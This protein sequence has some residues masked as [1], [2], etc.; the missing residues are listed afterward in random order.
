MTLP[1]LRR[2]YQLQIGSYQK[3]KR[4]FHRGHWLSASAKASRS[5]AWKVS[6]LETRG[7]VVN[8]MGNETGF[9]NEIEAVF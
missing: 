2:R 5:S 7:F 1:S 9:R 3:R 4:I 6:S 8:D